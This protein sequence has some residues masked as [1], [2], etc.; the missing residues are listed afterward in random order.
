MRLFVIGGTGY[1]GSV[2][3]E[4]LQA[5]GHTLRGL[6]RSDTSATQLIAA[7]IEPVLGAMGDAEV[8][9]KESAAAE[10]VVQIATGGFLVQALETVTE[11]AATTDA[12][13]GAL[14]GSDKP[15][16]Y[17]AGTGAWLDTGIAWPER[18]VTEADPVTPPHFYVHLCQILD[19]ALGAEH[20]RTIVV[21]P[22]QLYGRGGGYIGPIA[23]MFNGLRKHGVVYA[24]N[25]DNAFTYVH[26]DDL[27]DLYSLVLQSPSARGLYFAATDTVMTLEV[28]R[29]V[30][31]AAGL[32]GQ[33]QI[34]D[35]L[36]M[37]ALSGR[38][39]ELDFFANCRAS[40][41]K[42]IEELGWRPHRPG[43][44]DELAS[45]PTPLDVH[46]VYPE[47]K[48]QAAAARVSF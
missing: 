46:S 17:T 21:A 40:S 47:P 11:A 32:G 23:R 18:V 3:C 26:V 20:V 43:V 44:I 19:K 7:G 39:N 41:A 30:S 28:A 2:V 33:L 24:V 8:I 45:L 31:A 15:Y 48:R 36:T 27:A 37:R 9:G 29:A 1:I 38:A 12:V 14:A 34:V 13:L 4:R 42:A 25:Y 5:D 6:A 35:H 16:V 10:G 22:G